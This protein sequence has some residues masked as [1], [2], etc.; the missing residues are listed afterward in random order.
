M[1]ELRR[2]LI[3][4]GRLNATSEIDRV[5]TLNQK[6]V[7]YL[8]HV[9]RLRQGDAIEIVDG[10]G[11]L[12][13]ANLVEQHSI[14]LSTS[15][16]C[17]LKVQSSPKP[18]VGLAVVLPK[19]GLNELLRMSCEI[20]VDIIQPLISERGIVRTKAEGKLARWDGII[21]EA[22]EQSERLWKPEFRSVVDVQDWLK[23]KPSKA[24]FAFASPRLLRL[25]DLQEWVSG[26]EKEI[27]EIW[28]AIGPEGGWTFQEQL[29]AREA[30]CV[31]VHLGESIMRTSTAAVS[32][33]QLLVAWR[34]NKSCS[35]K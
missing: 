19:R 24:A 3:E 35:V 33:T 30:G 1:A 2:L 6:E 23:K 20:G 27:E 7:H 34:R 12:W 15:L 4:R 10:I 9:L 25:E 32:A 18:L 22:V 13:R 29:L 5:L 28:V 17:P 31:E 11:H 14:Q 26:F 16:E 21:R 8:C